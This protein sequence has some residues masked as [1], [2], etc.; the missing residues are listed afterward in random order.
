[1]YGT[2][3]DVLLSKRRPVPE[4]R[5]LVDETPQF[6]SEKGPVL[7][8]ETEP[9]EEFRLGAADPML[10]GQ[11]VVSNLRLVNDGVVGARYLHVAILRP[12]VYHAVGRPLFT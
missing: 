4:N 12:P 6:S 9:T 7:L 10:S 3:H 5:L 1:M 8:L 2:R 11:Q